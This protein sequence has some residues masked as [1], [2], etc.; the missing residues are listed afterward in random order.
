MLAISK[1]R[2]AKTARD[3]KMYKIETRIRF[4]SDMNAQAAEWN[5][6]QKTDVAALRAIAKKS[7]GFNLWAWLFA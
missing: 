5:N 1:R 3:K 4:N 6:G 7:N 2:Q